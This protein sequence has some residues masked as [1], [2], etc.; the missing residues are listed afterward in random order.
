MRVF[1]NVV[2]A[3]TVCIDG[4]ISSPSA[5]S[6]SRSCKSSKQTLSTLNSSGRN[7]SS[8]DSDGWL[9]VTEDQPVRRASVPNY[10]QPDTLRD[11]LALQQ[12]SLFPLFSPI[13]MDSREDSAIATRNP[14]SSFQRRPVPEN[15]ATMSYSMSESTWEEY[16]SMDKNQ[17][18]EFDG[19]WNR[20]RSELAGSVVD[21]LRR[22]STKSYQRILSGSFHPEMAREN[23]LGEDPNQTFTSFM[24]PPPPPL[25]RQDSDLSDSSEELIH[26]VGHVRATEAE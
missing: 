11:G 16:K 3:T 9:A 26:L 2:A 8:S 12:S 5:A 22:G 18:R 20:K 23:P 10:T 25:H 15:Q 6:P 14:L 1:E 21:A 7:F 17:E 19:D 24:R 4:P 13:P